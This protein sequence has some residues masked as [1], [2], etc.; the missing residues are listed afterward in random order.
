M[1][2]SLDD[3]GAADYYADGGVGANSVFSTALTMP[4]KLSS[5]DT[6]LAFYGAML[7][8]PQDMA[9]TWIVSS[10]IHFAIGLH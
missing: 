10:T 1:E 2:S 5:S 6:A 8:A 4:E 7:H 3:H 9:P